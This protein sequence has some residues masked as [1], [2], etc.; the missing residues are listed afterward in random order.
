MPSGTTWQKGIMKAPKLKDLQEYVRDKTREEE[1]RN[2]NQR[3][4]AQLLKEK[5]RNEELSE[6]VYRA[7]R[8]AAEGYLAPPIPP[9]VLKPTKGGLPEVAMVVVSDTQ[10][11]KKTQTYNSDIC[12][13]RV[14]R[15]A[16]KVRSITQLQRL[17]HP[18]EHAR[19]YMLGDMVEG[20]LIFPHQPYQIDASLYAQVT[21]IGPQIFTDFLQQMLACFKTVHVCCVIGNHGRIGWQHNPTT[22]ADRMLYRILAHKFE[23]NPRITFQIPDRECETDWYIVDYPVKSKRHGVLLFHGYQVRGGGFAGFPFY[24]VAKRV[25]GWHAGAVPEP[26][27]YAIMGHYHQQTKMTLGKIKVWCNGTTESSNTWAQEELASMGD[28]SQLLLYM[29]PK[30]GVTAE[31][32]VDLR[33]D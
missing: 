13:E 25:W 6:A 27:R 29:H 12:A 15:Y 17:D 8:D 9:P 18:I 4:S 20:E 11:A 1:L 24:G 19:V 28:P 16:R 3:L 2:A 32:E 10:L 33:A 5:N 14:A 23:K 7:A 30:R 21:T 31:Y 22:N 26:F